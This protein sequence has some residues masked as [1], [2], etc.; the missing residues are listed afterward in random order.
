MSALAVAIGAVEATEP[1]FS[2]WRRPHRSSAALL[3]SGFAPRE[4]LQGCCFPCLAGV[5]ARLLLAVTGGIGWPSALAAPSRRL[6]GCAGW[7]LLRDSA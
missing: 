2:L 4:A 1:E 3:L 6:D 5:R 7:R